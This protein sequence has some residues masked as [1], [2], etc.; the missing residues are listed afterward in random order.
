MKE[1]QYLCP[2]CQ[3]IF[4]LKQWTHGVPKLCPYCGFEGI[5]KLGREK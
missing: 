1:Q 2:K 5:E 3:M 4:I